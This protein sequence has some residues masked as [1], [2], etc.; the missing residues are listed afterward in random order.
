ML[1]PWLRRL[2]TWVVPLAFVAW[3]PAM[4]VLGRDDAPVVLQLIG[5]LVAA[6]VAA[7]AF[8]TWTFAVR[9][10]RSTGS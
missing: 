5:P 6:V 4:Y 8:A 1:G 7:L 9:H 10:Y 2:L 3:F